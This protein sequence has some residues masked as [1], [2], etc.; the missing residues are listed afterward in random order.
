MKTTHHNLLEGDLVRLVAIDTETFATRFS[1][2]S[3]DSEYDRLLNSGIAYPY[4]A[5]GTK[6]FIDRQVEKESPD[7]FWFAIQAIED[8]R[9]IGDVGLDGIRWNH[10]DCFVGIGLGEREYW[11]KGYG[12]ELNLER[13]S[14]NVFAYNARAIRSYEKVGFIHEGSMRQYLNRDSQR[15]DILYM[16]ILRQEWEAL[17]TRK[18][19]A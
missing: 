1:Q 5:R 17:Y 19:H 15:W 4:S 8:A 9:P 6:A 3:R 11:S 16:G 13:V 14:L 7:N 18:T 12:T 2:W 10:G